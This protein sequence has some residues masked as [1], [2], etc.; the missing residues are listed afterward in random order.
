MKVKKVRKFQPENAPKA[1]GGHAPPGPAGGAYSTPQ[2]LY[3]PQ[4]SSWVRTREGKE[5]GRE[6]GE[7]GVTVEG[8]AG[9][10]GEGKGKE[11]RK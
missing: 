2:A 5:R 11:G 3:A 4:T 6:R 7:E 1:F 8:Q 9:R 10:E